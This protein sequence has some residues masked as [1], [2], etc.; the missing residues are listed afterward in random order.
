VPG[1]VVARPASEPAAMDE[2]LALQAALATAQDAKSSIKLSER[3]IVELVNKLKS[4][5]LLESTLLYTLNGKE[6]LTEARL[7]AEIKREVKRRGGRVPVTDLQPALNVD[8][9]HCERRARALAADAS[10]GVSL[11]EGELITP[12]FFDAVAAETDE[13]LRE[14]GVIGVGELARRHGLSADLMTKALRERVEQG[15]VDGRLEGGSIYT[16]G[17]VRRLRAQLRGAMRAALVPTTRDALVTNALRQEDRHDVADAALT[18][19]VLGDLARGTAPGPG[20]GAAK[21]ASA[22]KTKTKTKTTSEDD[23]SSLVA[24][25]GALRGGAWHPAVYSRAQAAAVGEVY[26]RSGVVTVEQAKRMGVDDPSS[27]FQKFD[28]VALGES[29]V[30]RRVVEQFDAAVRDALTENGGWCECDALVPTDLPPDDAPALLAATDAVSLGVGSK[31][32]KADGKT[33]RRKDE[34]KSEKKKNLGEK[35]TASNSETP[36]ESSGAVARVV[37]GTDETLVACATPAFLERA[38]A[39]ARELGTKSGREE[40]TRRQTATGLASERRVPGRSA[41]AD[42]S[43]HERDSVPAPDDSDDEASAFV[44]RADDLESDDDTSRKGRKGKKGKGKAKKGGGG[45]SASGERRNDDGAKKK[46]KDA[47]DAND[48][49]GPRDP[50]F[51]APT[52]S[53]VASTCVGAAAPGASEAFLDAVSRSDAHAAALTAFREAVAR[54]VAEG[55]AAAF[56][57]RRAARAA[58][59]AAFEALFPS[60]CAF[61]RGAALLADDAAAQTHCCV[62]RV[63]PCVDAFLVSRTDAEDLEGVSKQSFEGGSSNDD[64]VAGMFS[65]RTRE[66]AAFGFP[67]EAR[68]AA[69]ALASC[70]VAAKDPGAIVA[71]LETAAEAMSEVR[72]GEKK[73]RGNDRKTERAT[74]FAHKKTLEETLNAAV[75]ENDAA[76]AFA[77]AAP[78]ALVTATGR[79]VTLT[80]RSFGSALAAF[81]ANGCAHGA[82]RD[83]HVAFLKTFHEDLVAALSAEKN[84][85]G[86]ALLAALAARLPELKSVVAACGK[87]HAGAEGGGD[88]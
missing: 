10:N 49:S 47:K 86:Q 55:N 30:S 7:D 69:S 88:E 3:N 6:Y 20:A 25:D 59:A 78:L 80:G 9:V 36:P 70:A 57:E 42:R 23:T 12:A 77:A 48:V 1:A 16:P 79:A 18:G 15:A 58:A 44:V 24:A 13:E 61:A 53:E 52:I 11:V 40:G 63:L 22:T 62:A 82:L 66:R 65:R 26:S 50:D 17:Y 87:A 60:A 29:F 76:R 84:E 41:E 64:I 75:A 8:V 71:A 43:L 35:K 85:T 45:S 81:D 21:K 32:S 56:A 39:L 74:I 14:A 73:L 68:A 37:R 67:S 72:P 54:T 51:G 46:P 83:E 27:Y 38:R 31:S 2:I 4:L 34:K 33:E 28:A 19:A 5:D